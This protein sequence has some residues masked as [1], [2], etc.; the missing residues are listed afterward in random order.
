[1]RSNPYAD[2]INNILNNR[3]CDFQKATVDYLYKRMV[4]DGQKR[5]LVA[6]EVGLGKTEVAKG[7][8]AKMFMSWFDSNDRK[9]G[10][11][12]NVFYICSNQSLSNQNLRKLN[13]GSSDSIVADVDRLT[14]F[15]LN[16][17]ET[18]SPFHLYS[19]TP[20]TSFDPKSSQGV[21]EER[22]IIYLLLKNND[23]INQTKLSNFMN[24]QYKLSSWGDYWYKREKIQ[25]SSLRDGLC[26]EYNDK[27][28]N[29]KFS[30]AEHKDVYEYL[31][32]KQELT[33][34]EILKTVCDDFDR[35]ANLP[36]LLFR[37]II[38]ELK[39]QLIETCLKYINANIF[40][41]DEF[42]RYSK[43]I[44][45]VSLSDE[46]FAERKFLESE[47]IARSIFRYSDAT[48]LMLSATPF[49]AFTN[50]IDEIGGEVHFKEF[51][52]VLKFLYQ[53]SHVDW[54]ELERNRRNFFSAMMQL[55]NV[56][57]EKREEY[58]ANAS[59]TKQ[60][61]EEVYSKVMVRTEKI[62]AA[63]DANGMTQENPLVPIK[64]TANDIDDFRNLDSV[65]MNIYKK[66][67]KAP[68]P[69]EY[70]K[71]APFAMS[72]LRDY[73][74]SV[75]A[76][77]MKGKLTHIFSRWRNAFIDMGEV[78]SYHFIGYGGSR[79]KDNNIWPNGKLHPLI[80]GVDK[81]AMLL[82]CPPSLPY[83]PLTGVFKGKEDF[84]KTLI[85]SAWKI[86][87]KMISTMLS[88]ETERVTIGKYGEMYDDK[89]K[90]FINNSQNEQ[91]RHPLGLLVFRTKE[92]NMTTLLLAYPS[93]Y[94]ANAYDPLQNLQNG[95]VKPGIKSEIQE[96]RKRFSKE[97]VNF[98]NNYNIGKEVSSRDNTAI[99][100]LLPV[101]EDRNN[102]V[103]SKWL[104]D[105]KDKDDSNLNSHISLLEGLLDGTRTIGLPET[106]SNKE[107]D[108]I[109]SNLAYMVIGSPAICAYRALKRYCKESKERLLGNAMRIGLKFIDLFNK[110]ESVAI[111]GLAYPKNTGLG[112][113]EKVLRYCADGC[114]QSVLDEY[115]FMLSG[116]YHSSDKITEVI[117][118]QLSL[119]T[120]TLVVDDK[121]SFCADDNDEITNRKRMRTHYA[122]PFGIQAKAGTGVIRSSIVREAFNSPFR[123][124]VLTTTS[125]GQ[126]G[127]DFHY[128]CRKVIH[129]NLPNNPIDLEQREGRINRFRGKVI[130]QRIA[131]KYWRQLSDTA[132]PWDYLFKMAVKEKASARFPCDIVPNWHIEK[133]TS[134]VWIE[135]IVPMYEFSRDIEKYEAMKKALG[136]Y[137]M[138]FGQ[139]RQEELIE[140]IDDNLTNDEKET[141]LIDL[142]PI[143]KEKGKKDG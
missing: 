85:F 11:T 48:V 88:Y 57:L 7:L 119:R 134:N 72:F 13:F 23:D 36:S 24:G 60:Y 104:N 43:L 61:L 95:Y 9:D 74:I 118:N 116:D 31:N 32:I 69:I 21:K 71:S 133:G 81:H 131:D 143:K 34:W 52:K 123:P 54:K 115:V 35:R 18:K 86:V 94:L 20:G 16:P 113:W 58:I 101:Y 105:V 98:R 124:F 83:Y 44:E 17:K 59:K 106:I 139:P 37:H 129:W 128:Y 49:K 15:A 67:D 122:M 62:M 142:A 111:V 135:R 127:L 8:I 73:D 65:F 89:V 82:W 56:P 10:D 137:R 45:L 84:S 107:K 27:V 66:E 120:G 76:K 22:Y 2:S 126:E 87:P 26:L 125:I 70:A 51:M 12:F 25:E 109:A 4:V 5:M 114:L 77:D 100:W 40:I 53:D 80:K 75:K 41:M 78:N 39:Q 33:L 132:K 6:D 42:Q 112:Y 38:G 93:L 90:Y 30:I 110:P 136:K 19:L 97:I 96:L 140:A 55:K 46:E 14:L 141:L 28:K 102:G 108:K 138:A 1:M 68:V 29:K 103:S 92:S 91:R 47:S 130:R 50:E 117:S 3:L 99:N 121:D 79:N 63:N 64:V